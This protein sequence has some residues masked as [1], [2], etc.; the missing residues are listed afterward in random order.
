VDVVDGQLANGGKR[1]GMNDEE[2][3]FGNAKRFRILPKQ[4]EA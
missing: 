2:I 3:G 1:Q 4:A